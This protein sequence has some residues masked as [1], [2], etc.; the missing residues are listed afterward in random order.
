[1]TQTYWRTEQDRLNALVQEYRT[2]GYDVLLNPT[3]EQ[4]PD[5][6]KDLQPDLVVSKGDEHVVVEVRSRATL[7][8]KSL[9]PFVRAVEGRS[10]W[11]FELVV[12]NPPNSDVFGD[13]YQTL[14]RWQ[15][16]E[17]LDQAEAIRETDGRYAAILVWVAVEGALFDRLFETDEKIPNRGPKRLIKEAI[18]M[19][20]VDPEDREPLERLAEFRNRFVHAM[21]T[22]TLSVGDLDAAIRVARNLLASPV[23][24]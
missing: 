2:S 8:D 12:T 1:M 20:F 24:G 21:V 17:M 9:I 3:A 15:L 4:L 13:T 14:D 22:D 19:G 16:L 23:A 10:G 11:H 7:N 6:L 5:F 18:S